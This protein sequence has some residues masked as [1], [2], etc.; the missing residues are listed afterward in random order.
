M[1]QVLIENGA[2][3]HTRNTRSQSAL[4]VAGRGFEDE[5]TAM[6]DEVGPEP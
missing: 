6:E 1:W 3:A 4:D 2:A 5:P